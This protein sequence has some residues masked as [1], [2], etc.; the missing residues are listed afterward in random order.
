VQADWPVVGPPHK[1]RHLQFDSSQAE[2]AA[3]GQP[4]SPASAA[5][6]L[7]DAVS[8]QLL[9]SRAFARYVEAATTLRVRG[10]RRDVRRFRPGLDYT[11]A[12]FGAMTPVP[13]LD[14]TLC[15]V[16]GAGA[17]TGAGAAPAKRRDDED[18][19]EDEEDEDEEEDEEEEESEENEGEEDP[20]ASGDVG[21]FECYIEA[22]HKEGG[23]TAEAAEVYRGPSEGQG[24]GDDDD[25][26][27]LSLSPGANVLSLVMRDCEVMRFVKFVSSS[28]PS[29]RWDVAVEYEI[30]RGEGE[31]EGAEAKEEEE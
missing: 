7:L 22:D 23:D 27:L 29:S 4:L 31:G 9:K 13:R 10:C 21:G 8:R 1:R 30:E 16:G 25:T 11:V 17:G 2:P 28:A 19:D 20:W 15:F 18:E 14:A 26:S 6:R 24:E 3:A 12:H 5:G